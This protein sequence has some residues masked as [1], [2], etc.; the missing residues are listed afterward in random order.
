MLQDFVWSCLFWLYVA[1]TLT[2]LL[3][4]WRVFGKLAFAPL[5][6]PPS[7]FYPPPSTIHHPPS[8]IHHPPSTLYPLPSTIHPLPSTLYPPPSTL[9]HPPSTLHPLPSTLYPPPSTLHPLPSTPYPPPSTLHPPPVSIILCARNEA[10]NLRRY[11]PKILAQQY[12]GEWEVIVVDDASE[13]ETPAVLQFFLEKNALLRV[14]RLS[15]KRHAGKKHALA[16]GIAAAK[17]NHLL[18]TDADCE[19]VSPHWLAQM[20]RVLGERPETEIVLGYGPMKRIESGWLNT[21]SRFET[22]HTAMQYLSFALAGMPYMGVG[23]N[24]AFKRAAYERVGGFEA[25]WD[26]PS[27]DDDLLVNAAATPRNTAICLHPDAFV[28]SESKKTWREWV[29]QKQRHLG[30]GKRYRW[31]HQ[32]VLASISLSHV[33]HYLMFVALLA[34]GFGMVSVVFLFCLRSASLLFLYWKILPKLRESSLLS[35][36][37]ICDALLAAYYGAFVPF[38]LIK[39]QSSRS[40]WKQ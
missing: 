24:L 32:A 2:Q 16:Q 4:W 33:L 38:F 31:R 36:I 26:V 17:H 22:A 34:A 35:L 8:T 7:A 1:A 10:D 39:P 21:W 29:W 19:P 27:G 13:D 18:L 14:V 25:H 23:R 3:V 5:H 9:H 15:E 20:A 28:F 11:L 40:T 37:P 6:L 12:P 30:A